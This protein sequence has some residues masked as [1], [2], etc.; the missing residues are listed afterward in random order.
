MLPSLYLPAAEADSHF[1]LD[2]AQ[3]HRLARVLRLRSGAALTV[4]DGAGRAY[5][6]SIVSSG[7]SGVVLATTIPLPCPAEADGGRKIHIAQVVCAP[8]KMDWAVEKMTELGVDKITPLVDQRKRHRAG[9]RQ[10]ERWRRLIIAACEQCGRRTLPGLAEAQ[11]LDDFPVDGCCILLT[12]RARLPLAQVAP[13]PP[14]E[15]TLIVGG[16]S[17]FYPEEEKL[18]MDK[19]A[20]AAQ[21]GARIL[22]SETAG[23]AVLA[24]LQLA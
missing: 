8:A 6:A 17:G 23:L 5:H 15:I 3:S 20:G 2:A 7:K 12:P 24:R 22:R 1:T 4:F 11:R 18:L 21:L 10:C 14:Q 9:P 13:P 19:G 16:E